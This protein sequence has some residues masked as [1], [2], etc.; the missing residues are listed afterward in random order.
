MEAIAHEFE[1][2]AIEATEAQAAKDEMLPRAQPWPESVRWKCFMCAAILVYLFITLFATKSHDSRKALLTP[3]FTPMQAPM[4]QGLP[5]AACP[6]SNFYMSYIPHSGWGNQVLALQHALVIAQSLNRSL[7]LPGVLRHGAFGRGLCG[8]QIITNARY[9]ILLAHYTQELQRGRVIGLGRVLN[10]SALGQV[11][12]TTCTNIDALSQHV[13]NRSLCLDAYTT[14]TQIQRLVNEKS[15]LLRFG[16]MFDAKITNFSN[17]FGNF[18]I[19]KEHKD[20]KSH[21]ELKATLLPTAAFACRIQYRLD[22]QE[23]VKALGQVMKLGAKYDALH[24]RLTENR[25]AGHGPKEVLRHAMFIRTDTPLYIAT[26]DPTLLVHMLNNITDPQPRRIVTSFDWPPDKA[27]EI[28]A[29]A[30]FMYELVI[31]ILLCANAV[32]F[33]QSTGSFGHHIEQLRLCEEVSSDKHL[34]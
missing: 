17:F 8:H 11:M 5:G 9:G 24:L 13:N 14:D 31:D 7:L 3:V 6:P 12:E 16:S 4:L 27:N 25:M 19:P 34:H 26:D 10:I 28:M 20:Y 29:T 33:T 22:I 30:G 23:K 18:G 15:H 21:V 1:D 32:T 2:D